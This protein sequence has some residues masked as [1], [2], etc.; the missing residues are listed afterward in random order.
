[1]RRLVAILAV[2]AAL[3]GGIVASSLSAASAAGEGAAFYRLKDRVTALRQ[4]VSALTD[5][6]NQVENRV[7]CQISIPVLT[8]A[9]NEVLVL[10]QIC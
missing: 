8:K 7:A 5:R 10:T 9:G 6:L 3:T 2:S 4:E 1:M